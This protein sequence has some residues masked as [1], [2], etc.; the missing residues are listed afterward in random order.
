M[1]KFHL[2]TVYVAVAEEQGFAAA[3]RRLNMSPPAVTRAIASL[4][5]QLGVKLLNRTTRYVRASEIGLRYLE[6]AKR[7]LAELDTA[8]ETASG[9]NAEPQGHLVVTAPV[10]F[11]RLFVTGGIVDYL[12]KYPK[13]QVDAIFLDRVV[14]LLEEGIDVGVRIGEL[15]DSSMR[16]KRV[17]SVRQV[18]CASPAYLAKAGLPQHPEDLQQHTII[19]SKA[20]SGSIDWRFPLTEQ[21]SNKKPKESK[22]KALNLKPR[23]TVT[24]NDAAIQAALQGFGITRVLSYQVAEELAAGHLKIVLENYEPDAKP[25]HI[26]HREGRNAAIKVRAFVDVLAANLMQHKALN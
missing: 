13:M 10:L 14:N 18:L 9:I 12:N 5:D 22:Q 26:V 17:G 2:L 25:V 23:L 4:E 8:D 11:G 3:A 15:P 24:T 1:D 7:I 16:A 19:A 6:D 21:T 20:G